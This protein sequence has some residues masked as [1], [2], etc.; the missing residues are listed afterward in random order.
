[1]S[2]CA[3]ELHGL[4][5]M[6]RVA[7]IRGIEDKRVGE[8][9]LHV[10]RLEEEGRNLSSEIAKCKDGDEE[11]Q[12]L[13]KEKERL[14]ASEENAKTAKVLLALAEREAALRS[15]TKETQEAL[16]AAR[17]TANAFAECATSLQKAQNWG[18][19]V[20]QA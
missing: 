16:V 3:N 14:I 15:E 12:R 20:E 19:I 4:T 18:T 7:V 5:F 8:I 1:M 6:H 10:A 13:L 11:Y 17:E 2:V 9:H